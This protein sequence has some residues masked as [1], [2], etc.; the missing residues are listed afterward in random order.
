MDSCF[1]SQTKKVACSKG[2]KS[3]K[4]GDTCFSLIKDYNDCREM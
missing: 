4:P 1:K 3:T 2:E